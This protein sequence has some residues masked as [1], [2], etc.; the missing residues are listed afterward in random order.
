[1]SK[2]WQS[3]F[4]NLEKQEIHSFKAMY[5]CSG[6]SII[7]LTLTM[8]IFRNLSD[9]CLSK[10]CCRHKIFSLIRTGGRLLTGQHFITL[11]GVSAPLL[12]PALLQIIPAP[13]LYQMIC[14]YWNFFY[15]LY[16]FWKQTH[17]LQSRSTSA[18]NDDRNCWQGEGGKTKQ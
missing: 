14:T 8:R 7:L 5:V 16:N 9:V 1:M 4:Q 17:G 18:Y 12:P 10:G 11:S 3:C 15:N 13:S 6:Q 2:S